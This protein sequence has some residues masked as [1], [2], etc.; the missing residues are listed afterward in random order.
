MRLR[1]KKKYALG[2]CAVKEDQKQGARNK[3]KTDKVSLA[4]CS[5]GAERAPSGWRIRVCAIRVCA[6][7]SFSW[8]PS[9]S[10]HRRCGLTCGMSMRRQGKGKRRSDG[11]IEAGKQ[12]QGGRER[13]KSA[14]HCD[15]ASR[16]TIDCRLELVSISLKIAK[17]ACGH[18]L[19]GRSSNWR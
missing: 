1:R 14:F 11:D 13:K 2:G 7:Q 16:K 19:D 4:R 6:L 10:F 17:R 18:T 12:V 9:V 3:T 8:P 15:R 5:S